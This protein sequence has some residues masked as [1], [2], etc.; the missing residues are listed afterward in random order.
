MTYSLNLRK[1][2]LFALTIGI[3]HF[4][5]GQKLVMNDIFEMYSLDSIS[6]KKSCADK[7]FSLVNISE[8]HWI[9][10]YN[11][12]SNSDKKISF[13]RTF[14]KDT[15]ANKFASYHFDSFKDYKDL[16]KEIK[17][18]GFTFK[19]TLSND[20]GSVS[21]TKDFYQNDVYEI[22]L[23][24]ERRNGALQSF[25]LM[26]YKIPPFSRQQE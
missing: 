17:R 15:A 25:G 16:K 2:I 13:G 7:N 6:L 14:P 1:L 11:F 20:Y 26:L 22:M 24:E 3:S 12:R 10:N 19:R 23:S 21:Y 5:Y 8:D 18:S 9:F 4:T